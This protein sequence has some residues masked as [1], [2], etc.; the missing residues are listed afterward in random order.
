MFLATPISERRAHVEFARIH[1]A[2]PSYPF[3]TK[4]LHTLFFAGGCF[5][6]LEAFFKYL[7]GIHNTEVGY[8]NGKTQHP[9]YEDVCYRGTGHAEAVAVTYDRKRLTTQTLLE[10]FFEAIDPTSFDRQGNDCG[11]QYRTG[12]YYID[13]NDKHLIES[14]IKRQEKRYEKP[15][16]TEVAPLKGFWAAE[17]YHQ[18]YLDKNPNGY[19]HIDPFTAKRFIERKLSEISSKKIDEYISTHNAEPQMMQSTP[20][21]DIDNLIEQHGYTRPSNER[22]KKELGS[23][24]YRVTQNAATEFPYTN[25]YCN[26]FDK[27]IYVDVTTGEP[28]FTSYDKFESGC[29]WPSFSRPITDAVLTEHEDR[30]FSSIRTEVRSRIGDAHLGHVFSD[31]PKKH[32]GLRYCINSAALRFIPYE[33]MDEEGYAY[34]KPLF[35]MSWKKFGSQSRKENS[36]VALKG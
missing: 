19:C 2:Q 16:V 22:L 13:D 36:Q 10:A 27:G 17:E 14:E 5:W 31:G 15:I 29:G 35:Q 12:I 32:G 33:K 24:Q 11:K 20:E 1:N 4:D 3:E 34:L 21:F 6:G 7:P 25:S 30:T 28:L 8:A 9:S 23:E 26:T 18:N